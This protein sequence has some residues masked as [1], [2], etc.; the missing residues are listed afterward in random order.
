[1]SEPTGTEAEVLVVREK[2]VLPAGQVSDGTGTL[3]MVIFLVSLSVLF[4]AN[5]VGYFVIRLRAEDWPPPGMPGLPTG[6]WFSTLIILISSIT[7]Q[8]AVFAVRLDRLILLR[9][10][11]VLTTL[12]G[13]GF[14]VCQSLNWRRLFAA[15][16]PPTLNL[17]AYTFYT[18]TGL[19]AAH[20]LGGLIQLG[21]VTVKAF[22]GRY[23]SLF[24]P[25]VRYAAMYWHFLDV[26]WLILFMTLVVFD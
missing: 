5:L 13:L 6:L 22:R 15:Q 23:W 9:V 12:L 20:V 21:V 1:M 16:V 7:I 19:H 2:G 11:L 3:G 18:L 17:Y 4:A 25:G 24:H 10:L 8:G 26:V 14:L